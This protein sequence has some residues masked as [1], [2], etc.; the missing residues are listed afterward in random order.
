MDTV[1]TADDERGDIDR[2]DAGPSA[3]CLPDAFFRHV[4]SLNPFTLNRSSADGGEGPDVVHLQA[5]TFTRLTELAGE[6]VR[7]RR[8]LGVLLT[9]ESGAGKSHLLGRLAR[10][11]AVGS[12]AC[13]V[14]VRGLQTDPEL[15]PAAVMRSA[16]AALAGRAAAKPSRTP[17]Y[18]LAHGAARVALTDNQE[19]YSWERV[20]K[21][22]ARL[23]DRLAPAA[24]RVPE[25]RAT[26]DL[27]YRFFRSAARTAEGK[28]DGAVADMIL[29]WFTGGMLD[30]AEARRLHLPPARHREDPVTLSD[31]EWARQGLTALA[32][33]ATAA[34]RPFILAIDQAEE[35]DSGRFTA[36]ARF[37]NGFLDH[38]PGVLAVTAADSGAVQ[39][40]R[41]RGE[42]PAAAWNRLAQFTL[43]PARLRQKDGIALVRRRLDEAMSPF[44]EVEFLYRLRADAP[45]FP[46]HLELN[47]CGVWAR[48]GLEAARVAWEVEQEVLR[49]EGGAAWLAAWAERMA[50]PTDSGILSEPDAESSLTRE[51]MQAAIALRARAPIP[52]EEQETPDTEAKVEE[53]PPPDTADASSD[54]PDTTSRMDSSL[55]REQLQAAI[56]ERIKPED[57]GDDTCV[58]EDLAE[59]E[60]SDDPRLAARRPGPPQPADDVQL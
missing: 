44:K 54:E 55:T 8:G 32:V 2:T 34:G 49:R 37:L 13:F 45:L 1:P 53:S 6:A 42:V 26:F 47:A 60:R 39:R 48:E 50:P 29:R 9:G 22:F 24:R 27:L 16:G 11:S 12:R 41:D 58:A 5:E 38:A 3:A 51:Q 14:V 36:L 52:A 7:L 33:L 59:E 21:A 18:R 56:A 23:A 30:A 15:L 4:L 46:L 28:E 17:L 10:W 43:E 40:W 35:L 31:P 20:G 19:R 25:G 57:E